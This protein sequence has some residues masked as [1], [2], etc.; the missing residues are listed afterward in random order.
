MM[1]HLDFSGKTILV[2]GGS[3]G[4][5]RATA[6]AFAGAGGTVALQFRQGEAEARETL[7]SLS[8]AG[9]RMFRAELR[10]PEAAERLIEAVIS[11]YGN[12][13]VLV[14][15]AGVYVAH[16]VLDSDFGAWEEAW[17]D[18]LPLNLTAAA[19]LSYWAARHMAARKAGRIINVSSRGAFRGEA[20]HPAYAASKAGL[21]ALTQ[22]LALA[23]GAH[24]IGVAAVAP[25]FV[26]TDMT[27]AILHGPEGEAIRAQSPLNRVATPEEVAHAI[28]FLASDQA[29]FTT[30][31]ILDVNGASYLRM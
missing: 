21:N 3:R 23:L 15:N 25:G 30:G 26:E 20:S 12:L 10:D 7:V 14:N 17:S 28:L 22:S 27:A 8:G 13:D 4:I 1:A 11:H 29:L 16:P 18:T 31:T 6:V 5:G 24:G 19:H 2:T 9:H